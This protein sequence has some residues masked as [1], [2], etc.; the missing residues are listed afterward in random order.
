MVVEEN[1]ILNYI[2]LEKNVNAALK[3]FLHTYGNEADDDLYLDNLMRIIHRKSKLKQL[4][5][6]SWHDK[7]GHLREFADASI[8]SSITRNMRFLLYKRWNF[9]KSRGFFEVLKK[10]VD[11]HHI[12]LDPSDLGRLDKL[13]KCISDGYK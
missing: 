9:P 10:Y 2:P 7:N 6:G 1:K 4:L 3:L 11:S 8:I 13:A 5:S 12:I